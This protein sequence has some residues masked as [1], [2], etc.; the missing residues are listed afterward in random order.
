MDSL[1]DLASPTPV[2]IRT[3]APG[4]EAALQRVF[5]AVGDHFLRVTGRAAPDPDAAEREIRGCAATP[6][7]EVALLLRGDDEVPVGALGWW[8]HHPEPDVALLGML[9][10][11]PE[12]RGGGLARS[13]L[14]ALEE[15]LTADGIG[16]LRAGVAH[17][18]TRAY[19]VLRALGFETLD[20]RTHVSLDYGRLMISLWEK[21]LGAPDR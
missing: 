10:I 1:P 18:D 3:L 21:S 20:Q 8:Q 14:A 4:D 6:G 12:R 17:S 7:R 19:A 16:R 5:A 2:R 9:M 11:V 15:R 13:A